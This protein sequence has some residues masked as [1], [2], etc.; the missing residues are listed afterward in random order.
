M[1]I[2]RL[3]SLP[4]ALHIFQCQLRGG[5]GLCGRGFISKLDL[6]KIKTVATKPLERVL[7][8]YCRKAASIGGAVRDPVPEDVLRDGGALP[9]EAESE[10]GRRPECLG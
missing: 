5:Q 8:V 1:K 10:G 4:P 9:R 6:E 2:P 7:E 3:Q